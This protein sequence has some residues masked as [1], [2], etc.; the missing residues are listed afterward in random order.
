MSTS[1]STPPTTP[2]RM[3][4]TLVVE[5]PLSPPQLLPCTHTEAAEAVTADAAHG[6]AAAQEE[7]TAP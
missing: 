2:P 5:P 7:T 3:A 1:S 6:T 4:P